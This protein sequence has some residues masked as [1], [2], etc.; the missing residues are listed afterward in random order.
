[1]NFHCLTLFSDYWNKEGS[2]VDQ[3]KIVK[4]HD[5]NKL[6]LYPELDLS[7]G[8]GGGDLFAVN[9]YRNCSHKRHLEAV[10]PRDPKSYYKINS[11]GKGNIIT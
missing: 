1:M 10:I 3:S 4:S 7:R 2:S 6:A 11:N 5:H 9:I 8:G